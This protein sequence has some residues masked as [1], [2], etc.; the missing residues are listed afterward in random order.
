MKVCVVLV[1]V[2]RENAV[3]SFHLPRVFFLFIRL[4]MAGVDTHGVFYNL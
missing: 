3:S 1:L 4:F 2:L